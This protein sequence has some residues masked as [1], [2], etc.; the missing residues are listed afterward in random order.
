[1]DK[2]QKWA[3]I[4]GGLAFLYINTGGNPSGKTTFQKYPLPEKI[5]V[6]ETTTPF[7]DE[8]NQTGKIEKIVNTKDIDFAGHFDIQTD[9]YHLTKNQ[10]WL[11]SRLIGHLTSLPRKLILWDWNISWGPDSERSRAALSMLENNKEIRDITVRLNYNEALYDGYRMFT[12]EKLTERNGFIPRATLGVLYTLTGELLAELNRG[13]YYNPFTK[14]AVNYSNVESIL[15]H[16]VGHHKDFQRFD[17]DW[18][19]ALARPI[20]PVMLYQEAAAS[21]YAKNDIMSKEDSNQFN[22]YLIPAFLTYLLGAY[23]VTRKIFGKR[24]QEVN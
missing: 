7:H 14:T 16:E 20:P 1:M 19:Y 9:R 10:D 8:T 18:I 24:D 11:P 5:S 15:A 17:R 2:I 6:V 13:D 12:E 3:L 22:R 4:A 21:L 23:R